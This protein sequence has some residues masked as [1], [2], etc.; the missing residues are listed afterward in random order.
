MLK[1]S[2]RKAVNTDFSSLLSY[3]TK[4]ST[5]VYRLRG[6]RSNPRSPPQ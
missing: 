3:S 6:G 1:T 2:T 5:Q 4:E